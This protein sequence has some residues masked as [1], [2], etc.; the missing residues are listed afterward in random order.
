MTT[1]SEPA[2]IA[3][4]YPPADVYARMSGHSPCTIFIESCETDADAFVESI[5]A[6]RDALCTK[7]G[8]PPFPRDEEYREL[9]ALTFL[10]LETPKMR[11]ADAIP[12]ANAAVDAAFSEMWEEWCVSFTVYTFGAKVHEA[13]LMPDDSE[14]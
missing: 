10:V 9:T 2:W 5:Y 11:S 6:A 12:I 13:R 14:G 8:I 7:L 4:A 1:R 3:P